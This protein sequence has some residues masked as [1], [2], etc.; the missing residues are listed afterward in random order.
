MSVNNTQT[1]RGEQAKQQLLEA[2]LEIFGKS[3]LTG[4]TTREIALRAQQ[5]IAAIAYYFGSKEGLYQAVAQYITDTIKKEFTHLF[6]EIDDFF[7]S[8]TT[9][10][11]ENILRLIHEGFLGVNRLM[12]EKES[13]N[14]SRIMAREQLAP[15]DAY[16]LIHEQALMPLHSRLNKLIARYIGADEHQLSTMLHAH[17]LMGEILTFRMARETLLRQTGW[18]NIGPEEYKLIDQI[19]IQHI[20]LLLNGLKKQNSNK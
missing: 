17:A 13:I 8:S 9:G 1:A 12:I 6:K 2:A 7:S 16:T 20:D 15:T 10:A 14:I 5:N 4:A 19:L 3:G 11:P 18:N